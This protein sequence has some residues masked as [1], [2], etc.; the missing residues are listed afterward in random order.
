MPNG[1]PSSLSGELR[2]V[3]GISTASAPSWRGSALSNIG[4]LLLVYYSTAAAY[5][6]IRDDGEFEKILKKK[7]RNR[8]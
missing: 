5:K 1:K 3:R 8:L 7:K 2:S 4:I 6:R